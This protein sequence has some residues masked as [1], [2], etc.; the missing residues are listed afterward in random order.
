MENVLL[1]ASVIIVFFASFYLVA[2]IVF[3]CLTFFL[4]T[5]YTLVIHDENGKTKKI[6]RRI[7]NDAEFDSFVDEYVNKEGKLIE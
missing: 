3:F 6:R 4:G 5:N 2:K 1:I 7:T